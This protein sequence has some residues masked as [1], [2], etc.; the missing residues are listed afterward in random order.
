MNILI[1]DDDRNIRAMI[2]ECLE[3]E[4]T[5]ID[6]AITGEQA[7]D[8]VDAA[9]K[10]YDVVMLDMKMP[11]MGGMQA[12]RHMKIAHPGLQVVMITAYGTVETAVEAIKLGAVDYLR[13]PFTPNAVR[14][15]VGQVAARPK[16][17]EGAPET[18]YTKLKAS[19]DEM[20]SAVK[21]LL[22]YGKAQEA[23]TLLQRIVGENPDDPEA[24]NL[25]GLLMEV[26]GDMLAAQRM[27]RAALGLDPT[28]ELARENLANTT[29]M[30]YRNQ[31][32]QKIK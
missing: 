12:L 5:S 18:D 21:N 22:V 3:Q 7:I 8:K 16:L 2:R 32:I 4:G 13:K 27:Y 19:R 23:M 29:E 9:A 31:N 1:V 15:I 17:A 24:Y 11:G 26:K 14:T 6:E 25:L 20:I 10:P 28:Y 30:K